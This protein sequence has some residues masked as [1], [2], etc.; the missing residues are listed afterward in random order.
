MNKKNILLLSSLGL[1]LI[2]CNPHDSK[3]KSQYMVDNESFTENQPYQNQ[4]ESFTPQDQS[5]SASDRTISQ[6]VRQAIMADDSLSASG[7]N[8][9]IITFN[10][11]VTLKGFVENANEKQQIVRKASQVSGVLKVNDQIETK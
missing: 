11:K 2:A 10:G 3:P 4:E 1:I 8:I 7:K 5:E 6:K 9:K